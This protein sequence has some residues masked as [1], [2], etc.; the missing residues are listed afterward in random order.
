MKNIS[1]KE[2]EEKLNLNYSNLREYS[3]YFLP[4]WYDKIRE[5]KVGNLSNG[6]VARLIRQNMYIEYIVPE[7]LER[8]KDNPF[9]GELY[10]GEILKTLYNLD[11]NFWEKNKKSKNKMSNILYLLLNTK[12]YKNIWMNDEDKDEFYIM[13]EKF[14]NS[15]NR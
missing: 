10:D 4:L 6:D 12:R 15:I 3:E 1:I 5:K 7:A 13:A 11:F 8:L 14:Q 9:L 2:I